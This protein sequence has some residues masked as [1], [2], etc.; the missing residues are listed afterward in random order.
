M[1]DPRVKRTKGPSGTITENNYRRKALPHLQTDFKN[2]CAY[3]LQQMTLQHTNQTHVEHFDSHLPG[4]KKHYYSNLMLSCSACNLSKL[5]KPVRD[6]LDKTR[7]M[8][9]CTEENEFPEHI[10]EDPTSSIWEPKSPAGDYHITSMDLN[11]SS[12][13]Q[14]RQLRNELIRRITTLRSGA[15][16]YYGSLAM[17]AIDGLLSILQSLESEMG[18]ALPVPTEGG[19]KEVSEIVNSATGTR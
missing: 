14:K 11:E 9:K 5:G 17:D 4:R 3:C 10:V 15:K 1:V 16:K 19:L 6:P 18:I 7:R 8:L 2:R 13:I 12:H